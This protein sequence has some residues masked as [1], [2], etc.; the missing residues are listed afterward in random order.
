MSDISEFF[1]S[2]GIHLHVAS[3]HAVRDRGDRL[4]PV[5]LLLRALHEVFHDEGICQGF[6]QTHQLLNGIRVEEQECSLSRLVVH[7]LRSLD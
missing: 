5:S 7:R 4:V 1:E 2:L 3:H 6:V